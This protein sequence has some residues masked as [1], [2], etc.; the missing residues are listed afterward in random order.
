MICLN[1][2]QGLCGLRAGPD[3]LRYVTKRRGVDSLTYDTRYSGLQKLKALLGP[4]HKA[5]EITG[6]R[7]EEADGMKERQKT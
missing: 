1:T 7:E 6:K 5:G 3:P 4:L 2:S